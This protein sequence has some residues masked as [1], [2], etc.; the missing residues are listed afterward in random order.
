MSDVVSEGASERLSTKLQSFYD[1]LPEDEQDVLAAI[2]QHA[3]ANGDGEK[4]AIGLK[5]AAVQVNVRVG[6]DFPVNPPTV[7]NLS[8]YP[9]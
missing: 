5:F 4:G 6:S 1:D 8:L 2:L 7:T 9:G 3:A